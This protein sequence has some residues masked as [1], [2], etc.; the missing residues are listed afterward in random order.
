MLACRCN[1]RKRSFSSNDLNFVIKMKVYLLFPI[2]FAQNRH[3]SSVGGG[4]KQ[5]YTALRLGVRIYGIG[6]YGF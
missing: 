1:T 4:K 6:Q 2:G 3:K 5:K